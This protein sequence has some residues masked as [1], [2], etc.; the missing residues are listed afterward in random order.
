MRIRIVIM[1]MIGK[2]ATIESILVISMPIQI[3]NIQCVSNSI[4][5]RQ[6]AIQDH[7]QVPNVLAK[8]RMYH[9][10]QNKTISV[11]IM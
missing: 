8:K 1:H 3:I 11:L 6:R 9:P 10:M 4:D 2:V 7:K 5:S